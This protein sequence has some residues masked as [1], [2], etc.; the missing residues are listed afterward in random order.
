MWVLRNIYLIMVIVQAFNG[1]GDTA[2]PT[3]VDLFCYWMREIPLAY[4]LAKLVGMGP[5]GVF[6]A[7][8]IA[9]STTACVGVVMFR[10]GRWKQRKV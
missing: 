4:A 5:R 6:L 8:A 10:R 7:I 2:T 1:A 3:M 9:E